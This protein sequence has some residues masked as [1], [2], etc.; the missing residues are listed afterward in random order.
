M[1]E[2]PTEATRLKTW[3]RAC[4]QRR[5]PSEYEVGRGRR[6]LHQRPRANPGRSGPALQIAGIGHLCQ[7]M[8]STNLIGSP[9]RHDDWP[10]FRDPEEITYPTNT[11]S[12]PRKAGNYVAEVW[13]DSATKGTTPVSIPS[14]LKFWRGFIRPVAICFTPRRNG[15]GL[16]CDG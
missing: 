16:C 13:I 15:F 7:P 5:K 4:G 3:R 10:S 2:G 11:T 9:L 8:V 1:R 12:N 14:G 6:A